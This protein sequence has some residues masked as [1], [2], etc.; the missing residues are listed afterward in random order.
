MPVR[1]RPEAKLRDHKPEIHIFQAPAVRF[2]IRVGQKISHDVHPAGV[3]DNHAVAEPFKFVK[4]SIGQVFGSLAGVGGRGGR[5]VITDQNQGG[6]VAGYRFGF[7]W[8][9][10]FHRPKLAL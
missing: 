4:V 9:G 1:T 3:A 7:Q 10:R 8:P 6:D 5:I 2:S